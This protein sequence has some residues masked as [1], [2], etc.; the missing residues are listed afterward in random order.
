MSTKKI[1]IKNFFKKY[2]ILILAILI[3]IIAFDSLV[4]IYSYRE[5]IISKLPNFVG[6]TLRQTAE[7]DDYKRYKGRQAA[8]YYTVGSKV[9]KKILNGGYI[10][11]FRHAEREKWLDV[12]FYDAYELEKNLM[13][14]ETHFKDAV[15][16]STRGKIQARTMGE[17]VKLLKI[18][19]QK[20]ISSPSCR[21]RQTAQLAFGGYDEIKNIFLHFGP[22]NETIEE[23]VKNVKK[24][25]LKINVKEGSNVIISAHG[26]VIYNETF[27]EILNDIS[28]FYTISEGGFYVISKKNNKLALVHKYDNFQ[29]FVRH[30]M[31]RPED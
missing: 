19:I 20:V 17:F 11:Y 25:I 26:A 14:E 12:T 1:S 13:A 8:E 18:P 7:V 21:A 27:D 29:H 31:Q 24:E 3:V 2:R 30:L 4:S 5:K 10:L 23:Y 9:A 6:E 16:L 15:C 28:D 22:F